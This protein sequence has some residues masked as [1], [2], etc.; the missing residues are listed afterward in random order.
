MK[1]TKTKHKI[2]RLRDKN[3]KV[4]YLDN[5]DIIFS[6]GDRLITQNIESEMK[7]SKFN[8][9][10]WKEFFKLKLF[11]I[12]ALF[13]IIPALIYI[14]YWVGEFTYNH[15]FLYPYSYPIE[16]FGLSNLEYW[17]WGLLTILLVLGGL[18]LISTL[19]SVWINSNWEWAKKRVVA[20]EL[21]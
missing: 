9:N 3:N 8:K 11:E 19:L 15:I 1:K 7:K 6:E 17:T 20:R 2:T 18:M 10:V 12:V 21:K 14:P 13:G 16:I 4:I 5:D